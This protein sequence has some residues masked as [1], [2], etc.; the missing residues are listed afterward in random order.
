[1]F[2]S[3]ITVFNFRFNG[4]TV[5]DVMAYDFGFWGLP[6]PHTGVPL[7][8][9]H[10]LSFLSTKI[11]FL[12]YTKMRKAAGKPRRLFNFAFQPFNGPTD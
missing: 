10:N 8:L 2:L 1:M 3:V 4:L 7:L 12:F 6:V 5:R 11:D 9:Y